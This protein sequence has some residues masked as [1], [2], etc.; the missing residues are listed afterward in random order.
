MPIILVGTYKAMA[1]LN[2][3]F[4]LARRS[5]GLGDF[6]W[7][8]M[9]RDETWNTFLESL[10]RF[11]YTQKGCRLTPQ[12]N[13]TLYDVSQGITDLAVKAYMLAQARAI[14]RGDETITPGLIRSVAHDSFRMAR[15]ILDALKSGNIQELYKVDDV[16]PVD[17]ETLLRAI[18]KS[19]QRPSPIQAKGTP[20]KDAPTPN[21]QETT[22]GQE[23]LSTT[24]PAQ[25]ATGVLPEQTEMKGA[26]S[27][28]ALAVQGR[29]L[30]VPVYDLMRKTG[31]LATDDKQPI[32][33]GKR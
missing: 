22:S 23:T 6:V 5:A 3:E 1:M 10:W 8:S 2:S 19:A 28:A 26:D 15:P 24:P 27:L 13:R 25:E 20:G 9:R 11:Q 29:E 16:L 30:G 17:I 31:C 21:K 12:L 4:R 33:G 7:D 14:T 32:K 18:T